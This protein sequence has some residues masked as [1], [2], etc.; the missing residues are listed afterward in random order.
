MTRTHTAA[1]AGQQSLTL[2]QQLAVLK[3]LLAGHSCAW[4]ATAL[5]RP[6]DQIDAI[7]GEHGYPDHDVMAAVI[8][9][10]EEQ[11]RDQE[12]IPV[13]AGR[14][15]Q[16]TNGLTVVDRPAPAPLPAKP[17]EI[18]VLLNTGKAHPAKR[19]QAQTDRCFDAL[20]KLK[21]MIR[22]DE[23]KHAARRK[24]QAEKAAV[25]AEIT[26]LENQLRAARAKLRG[27]RPT[28]SETASDSPSDGSDGA[29]QNGVSE[30]AVRAWARTHDVECPPTGRVPKAV[31]EAYDHAHAGSGEEEGG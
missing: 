15:P 27:T 8:G 17:D 19:I 28:P 4:V 16:L 23:A 2:E 24:A 1:P 9:D 22:E 18:R 12:A 11:I 7:A 31:R 10:L 6:V 13:H 5:R 30:T 20:D 21:A 14:I 26:R 3:H 29:G 25:H